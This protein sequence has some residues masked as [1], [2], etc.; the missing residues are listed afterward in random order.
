MSFHGQLQMAETDDHGHFES[1]FV[2]IMLV[3]P[4]PGDC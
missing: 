2:A 1:L 3:P 4:I